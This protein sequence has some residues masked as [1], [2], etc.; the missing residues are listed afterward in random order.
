MKCIHHDDMDGRCAAAIVRKAYLEAGIPEG[1]MEFI[2]MSYKDDFPFD[3]IKDDEEVIIVDFSLQ[4]PGDFER[5]ME[6]TDN[7]AW[8]DHHISAIERFECLGL[9]GVRK[10]GTA[11]C[12]L[13]WEYFFPGKEV[14]LAVRLLGDYDVW[15]FSYGKDTDYFQAATMLYDTMPTSNIWDKWLDPNYTLKEEIEHGKLVITYRNNLYKKIVS[16]YSFETEFE[17]Y[18]AI[19]CNSNHK[20]SQLFD[21]I[22]KD[23]DLM[24]VFARDGK[25]WIVSLYSKKDNVDCSKIAMKYGGGGHKKAAGF[26]CYEL[27]F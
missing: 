18:K 8:I 16:S 23:Y 15:K 7:I 1:N 5:L 20:T 21:S 26:E 17:G 12:E 2:E 24:M 9:S 11:A 27:P 10:N 3:K 22:N 14:P 13:T 25:K 19:A 4:R 6:L